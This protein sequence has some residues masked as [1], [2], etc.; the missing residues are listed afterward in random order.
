MCHACLSKSQDWKFA[1]GENTQ[2]QKVK[3]FQIFKNG[4][5]V[6]QLCHLHAIQLFQQGERR[7]L[8][9]EQELCRLIYENQE[10]FAR[11]EEMY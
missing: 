7:F 2:L 8:L 9:N 6:V 10:K 11:H 5:S 1:N 3:L 4:V